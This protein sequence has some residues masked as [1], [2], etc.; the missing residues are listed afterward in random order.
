MSISRSLDRLIIYVPVM[1][2]YIH[3][4]KSESCVA[5]AGSPIFLQIPSTFRG[6]FQNIFIPENVFH[7]EKL[8]EASAVAKKRKAKIV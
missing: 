3:T 4:S 5:T 8:R 1:E 6:W 7:L 2:I